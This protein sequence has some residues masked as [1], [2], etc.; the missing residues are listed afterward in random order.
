MTLSSDKAKIKHFTNMAVSIYTFDF[1]VFKADEISV[2]LADKGESGRNVILILGVD[3][4]VSGLGLD[5]GGRVTLTDSGKA[6]AGNNK[7]LVIMRSMPFVQE[8]DYRP[9][10]LFPAETHERCLDIAV[11]ERQELR[12]ALSRAIKVP[13]G[14]S[15]TPEDLWLKFWEAYQEILKAYLNLINSGQ[16]YTLPPATKIKLGGVK[17]GD[18]LGVEN[19]GRLSVDF[20]QMPTDKFELL[21]RTIRVPFWLTAN[22]TWYVNGATGN[23]ANNGDTPQTAFKTP[24]AAVNYVS[25]NYNLSQYRA[26]IQLAAGVYNSFIS[27]PKYNASIGGITIQG[28]GKEQTKLYGVYGSGDS[29][30]QWTISDLGTFYPGLATPGSVYYQAFR[31]DAGSRMNI[32]NVRIDLGREQLS[33][34]RA[35]V[36]STGGSII[37]NSGVEMLGTGTTGIVCSSAGNIILTGQSMD[38]SLDVS[39]L[40]DIGARS[41]FETQKASNGTFPVI[42]GTSS[43]SC[44]RL[45][46]FGT[47]N[48]NGG[49]AYFFPGSSEGKNNGGN[50][51]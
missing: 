45:G 24:Q 49:G 16:I 2:T 10:D 8:T 43:G 17:V 30:G 51:S 14:S 22:R 18:G 3:Y 44:Y 41:G 42:T 34:S 33:I 48:T 27:L 46:A 40:A 21:L 31:I 15:E 1:K 6:K 29:V 7:Y 47:I 50:Y 38:M 20:T 37:F 32:S 28:A 25:E 23:D 19:D 26:T 12:E 11:M 9:H 39:I 13:I 36:R 35:C 4:T 5:S